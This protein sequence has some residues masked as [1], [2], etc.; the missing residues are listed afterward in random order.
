MQR[1]DER[2][3]DYFVRID[4]KS[5]LISSVFGKQHL[6]LEKCIR[7][8]V[9]LL[10]RLSRAIE[11]LGKAVDRMSYKELRG[12]AMH[13]ESQLSSGK[14]RWD[15]KGSS[16]STQQKREASKGKAEG[17]S[18]FKGTCSRCLQPGHSWRY[19]RSEK[20]G[21]MAQRC[22][23]CGL[24]HRLVDCTIPPTV[25]CR[26]CSQR[27]HLQYVCPSPLAVSGQK[28]QG[29][30]RTSSTG[31]GGSIKKTS[32]YTI[33]VGCTP[34]S[35]T[36]EGD[37]ISGATHGARSS[38]DP[39]SCVVDLTCVEQNFIGAEERQVEDSWSVKLMTRPDIVSLHIGSYE[40]C[41]LIDM[42]AAVGMIREEVASRLQKE[43]VLTRRPIKPVIITYANQTYFLIARSIVMRIDVRCSQFSR[44]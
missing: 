37:A 21:D 4:K 7:A 41:G 15:M 39:L 3:E 43:G 32:A 35:K 23:R 16:E 34:Q 13:F 36:S 12:E 2:V 30:D 33:E 19:C 17:R 5:T 9:G 18:S 44:A 20:P 40:L 38:G 6:E 10:P 14:Y 31:K 25:S 1:E 24:R 27:G 22:S 8:R 29:T 11:S 28:P 42:G 26:R